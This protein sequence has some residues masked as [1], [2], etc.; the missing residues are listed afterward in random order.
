MESEKRLVLAIALSVLVLVA[1]SYLAPRRTEPP[2]SVEQPVAEAPAAAGETP[3]APGAAAS[4]P[5]AE[6][7]EAAIAGESAERFEVDNGLFRVAL[8]SRGG[9][10]EA[11]TLLELTGDGGQP[12][13]VFPRYVEPDAGL[14]LGLDLDDASVASTL[15]GAIYRV[16]REELPATDSSPPGERVRFSWADGRGLR[17]EK[18]LEF[19]RGSWIVDVR[20][21]VTDRGRRLPV[22]LKVG[23]GFAAQ[24]PDTAH[25]TYHY[26]S[27]T[28]WDVAGR[29]TRTKRGKLSPPEGS[30]TGPVRWA[31]IEDQ[32]FAVLVL[33]NAPQTL[34]RWRQAELTLLTPPAP[35]AAP[36]AETKPVPIP[37]LAVALD[38]NGAGLF[39]GP[40]QYRLLRDIGGKRELDRAVWFSSYDW[41]RE[42]V[43]YLFLGLIWLHDRVAQNWGMT[44]ILATVA[45]RLALFPV[46]QFSMVSMKRTQLQMQKLQP[47]IKTI[48]AKYKKTNDAQSR[49]KMNEELMDL[50]RK[51]GINPMGGLSGCLP[52]LAQFPILIG[53]YNMLTVAV[54]L[55]G[56][57][58]ILWI[59]DLSQKDPA[60]VLPVLMAVTM[61]AQ[62]WL[63]ISKVKDPQQLQQQRMMLFMPLVF[64]F[65][66]LQMPSGLVL[67]W[68]VNNLLGMGQQ[69]L[70]NHHADRL[71]A[72]AQKA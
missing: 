52:M 15:N 44:I 70:V 3:A 20:A 49:A 14:P 56:A 37:V 25:G 65:I 72:A 41:L 55:R 29:V 36:A 23:P 27:Q 31:G 32:Y 61:F 48:R 10:A 38:E 57:P 21:E 2:P 69:W 26:E 42:I 30:F 33:P 4:E 71:E 18:V 16:E 11:W 60:H 64:G 51:E 17:A 62:Q 35:G 63:A 6:P 47:K 66:C 9:Q 67:Y 46:N 5:A 28:V 43:K 39:V 50:Y 68:F 1:F 53:F 54:E 40:K 34:V 22:R 59:R 8:T 12:L 13:D 19:H 7:I 58:F 24:E 45:L